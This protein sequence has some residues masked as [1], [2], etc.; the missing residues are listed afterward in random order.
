[1]AAEARVILFTKAPEPGRVKTRLIPLLGPE[2]AAALQARLITHA[3]ETIR[4]GAFSSVELHGDPANDPFLQF[5]A[6]QYRVPL[7][8]QCAGDLGVRMH[9]AFAGASASSGVLLV[10][11]DCPALTARHLREAARTLAAGRDAVL[12]PVEDGGYALIG[13]RR[14]DAR[15][16]EGIA[17]GTASVL[18]QTR[19]RLRQLSMNWI[20]LETLWDVDTVADYERLTRSRLL[21]EAPKTA[22]RTRGRRALRDGF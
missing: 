14:P 10:G 2:G 5:C 8:E 13:L 16:F 12:G 21:A 6:A 18:E 3:L 20:E 22:G 4:G 17:W 19:E 15:L 1:M 9:H 11:S 7:V